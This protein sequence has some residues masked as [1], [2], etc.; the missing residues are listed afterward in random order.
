MAAAASTVGTVLS[1]TRRRR[2]EAAEK[3]SLLDEDI[4]QAF[5]D[6]AEWE[7]DL[8]LELLMLDGFVNMYTPL[9]TIFG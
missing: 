4:R 3:G 8:V 1:P 2:I 6:P 9:H 5:P 7:D